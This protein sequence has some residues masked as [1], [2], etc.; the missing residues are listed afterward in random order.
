MCWTMWVTRCFRD[1]LEVVEIMEFRGEVKRKVVTAVVV[2]HL[3]ERWLEISVTDLNKCFQE[4]PEVESYRT[5]AKQWARA[6]PSGEPRSSLRAGKKNIQGLLYNVHC[7]VYY[8]VQCTMY[9]C[10]SFENQWARD[11]A[12]SKMSKLKL[13][14]SRNLVNNH[15]LKQTRKYFSWLW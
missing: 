15:Q 4:W 5:K 9:N 12:A 13:Q 2:H 8:I 14:F 7:T 10:R 1:W 3:Q 11:Q 6:C